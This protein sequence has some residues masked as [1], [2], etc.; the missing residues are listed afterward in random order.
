MSK[1]WTHY[2]LSEKG[3]ERLKTFCQR[4]GDGVFMADHKDRLSCG[5]C[6]YTVWKEK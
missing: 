3:I 4:C 6:G 1:K 2:K 5:S